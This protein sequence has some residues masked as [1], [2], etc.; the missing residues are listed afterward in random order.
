MVD[1]DWTD[2]YNS[3]IDR[4]QKFFRNLLKYPLLLP[5]SDSLSLTGH[6]ADYYQIDIKTEKQ[7]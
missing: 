3:N 1:R 7:V 5:L 2:W 6:L 4:N